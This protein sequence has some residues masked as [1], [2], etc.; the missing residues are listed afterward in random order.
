MKRGEIDG[1]TYAFPSLHKK[2]TTSTMN[3]ASNGIPS[4]VQSRINRLESLVLSLMPRVT[5]STVSGAGDSSF[6]RAGQ[7]AKGDTWLPPV[8][9]QGDTS[10]DEVE[11]SELDRITKSVGNMILVEDSTVFVPATHWYTII[12]EIKE[13]KQWF[14]DH[15]MQYEDIKGHF[16]A[17]KPDEEPVGASSVFLQEASDSGAE[18]LWEFP[19]KPTCDVLLARF[20]KAGTLDPAYSR[21]CP[22][23]I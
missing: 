13:V 10:K 18:T 4:D 23:R 12:G 17:K 1:C 3:N 9:N 19:P 6:A 15:T 2:N 20:F 8:T 11:E 21:R 14:R 7:L 5:P 22:Q 16:K